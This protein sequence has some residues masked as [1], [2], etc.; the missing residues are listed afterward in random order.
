M[1]DW[2]RYTHSGK[3][4]YR[5]PMGGDRGGN[6]IRF[7]HIGSHLSSVHYSFPIDQSEICGINYCRE[8]V[9][10]CIGDNGRHR[11]CFSLIVGIFGMGGTCSSFNLRHRWG[12]LLFVH[13]SHGKSSCTE[14]FSEAPGSK[15]NDPPVNFIND[16]IM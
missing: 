7:S 4:F 14:R 13:N 8:N 5:P 2:V 6:S 15:D 16:R 1:A 12:Y 3:F 10:I 11:I 9:C